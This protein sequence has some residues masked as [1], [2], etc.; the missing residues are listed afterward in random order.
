MAEGT[1]VRSRRKSYGRRR[2]KP[3]DGL[4]GANGGWVHGCAR[5][6]EYRAYVNAKTLCMNPKSP[7]WK[8]L[9]GR[10][11]EFRLPSFAVF[12]EHLGRRPAGKVLDR[13][14]REGHFEIGN[15][16]WTTRR[17]S[18]RTRRSY[19][20]S[21]TACGHP[22][23]HAK[24]LCR[25]C[26]ESTPK[27]RARKAAWKAAQYVP[28]P[29][30][31]AVNS[32]GHLDRPHYAF[33]LCVVCYRISPGGRAVR[34]RYETSPKGKKTR[35]RYAATPASRAYQAAYAAAHYVPRPPRPRAVNTCWHLDG[36][37]RQSDDASIVPEP[38]A[39]GSRAGA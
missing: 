8:Y 21:R 32:C 16:R 14:N 4:F 5:T 15:V 38:S 25:S 33:G 2:P 10:G 17:K 31:I 7:Q 6:P 12:L 29:L 22:K 35:A 24:G 19:R 34:K 23:H 26:Y 39:L 37:T 20:K 30:E 9:G 18:A 3:P 11:I 13:P 28:T 27:I 36:P 1:K